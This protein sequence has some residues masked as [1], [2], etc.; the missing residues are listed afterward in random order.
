MIKMTPLFS[1]LLDM[2]GRI[3]SI[4][5]A[6]IAIIVI[7][8]LVHGEISS[9]SM[10]TGS[11]N[12]G[13]HDALEDAIIIYGLRMD[14]ETPVEDSDEMPSKGRII[15]D[16]EFG[17]ARDIQE[18][19]SKK[20]GL[21]IEDLRKKD[22][23]YHIARYTIRKND[24]LWSIAK[25]Y[26]TDYR[27]IIRLNNIDRPEL[28]SRGR[29]ISVP[30]RNGIS[31]VVKNGDTLRSIS[32]RFEIKTALIA[33]QNDIASSGHTLRTGTRIFI[34]DATRRQLALADKKEPS[35]HFR[36]DTADKAIAFRWPIR[37]R[38]SS[39]FGNRID[40]FSRS[41]RFHCGIDISASPGTPVL[42]AAGGTVIFNGWKDGYGNMVVVRHEKGYITVYAHNK[43]NIAP[44]GDVV[45]RGEK[46]ALSG[47][48][49]AVTGAHLH[50]E[51]RKY[52]TPLNPLKKLK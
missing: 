44:E 15:F 11:H 28:L 34:P 31:Y 12:K 26:N 48:T 3:S 29:V 43:L 40:P 20:K 46:I 52:L 23:R 19:V 7:T 17:D 42:A 14:A 33:S 51:I 49:G 36:P 24:N 5:A 4:S 39:G 38:I 35:S 27:L 30:H 41:R 16:D 9:G 18:H 21:K 13:A 50:F 25:K 22:P 2:S 32:R 47:M 1:D 8:Y 6:V 45:E 37:G 10:A